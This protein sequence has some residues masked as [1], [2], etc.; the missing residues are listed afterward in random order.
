VGRGTVVAADNV[1]FPGAPGYLE[2]LAAGR[3]VTTLLEAPHEVDQPWNPN[4]EMGR[5]DAVA[6]SLAW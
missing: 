2:H 4:W 6:V 3:Y 1:V 5:K